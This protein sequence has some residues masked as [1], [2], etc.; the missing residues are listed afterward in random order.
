M[1][2]YLRIDGNIV[3]D[4]KI[5]KHLRRMAM[6][7]IIKQTIIQ[8]QLSIWKLVFIIGGAILIINTLIKILSMIHPIVGTVGGLIALIGTIIG[9]F[10]IIYKHLASYNYRLIEDEL[11][12]ERV[13]GRANHLFLSLKLS[14]LQQFFPYLELEA[15]NK[16]MPST[17]L[18][19]FVTGK[20]KQF[21]YVGEFNRNGHQ[22]RFIIE[23]NEEL[24]NAIRSYQ[25]E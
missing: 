9:C 1:L 13:F 12:M 24:L 11:F 4:G 5:Q 19:K 17:K 20:N 18:Y 7:L 10:T 16:N 3:C 2:L 23:P 25:A 22:Y 14:E 6:A 21:W 8:K 15:D